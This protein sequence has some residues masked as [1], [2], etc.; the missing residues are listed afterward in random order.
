MESLDIYTDRAQTVEP[1][2]AVL[3]GPSSITW[4]RRRSFLISVPGEAC[5]IPIEVTYTRVHA[6]VSSLPPNA[7]GAEVRLAVR[8]SHRAI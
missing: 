7:D 4:A 1:F 2:L 5:Y 3:T 8:Y 6:I